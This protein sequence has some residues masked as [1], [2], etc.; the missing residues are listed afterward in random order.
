VAA[1]VRIAVAAVAAVGALVG[2]VALVIWIRSDEN[3]VG[4]LRFAA[5]S[6]ARA[7]FGEF[8][9]TRVSVGSRCL[10]VLVASTPSQRVQGLRDVRS[11]SPYAG[12]LF[13]NAS[14]TSARFTMAGTPTPLDVTFFSDEGVPVDRARMT[15]CPDGTDATCPEYASKAPYR[16]ALEQPT[17]SASPSGSLGPCTG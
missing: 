7:P 13:V 15:P 10:L 11:L 1:R 8:E 9:Q 5:T 16:Y 17:A 4:R 6:P 14:D 12:M 2:M 3:G